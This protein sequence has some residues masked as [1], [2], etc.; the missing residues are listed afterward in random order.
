MLWAFVWCLLGSWFVLSVIVLVKYDSL[1][2]L[3]DDIDYVI[4]LIKDK[5]SERKHK[6]D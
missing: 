2:D 4:E 3:A 5:R 1:E 6:N